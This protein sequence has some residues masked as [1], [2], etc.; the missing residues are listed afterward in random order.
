[1]SRLDSLFAPLGDLLTDHPEIE[2]VEI[3][4]LRVTARGLL[5]LDAVLNLGKEA[6]R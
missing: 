1:V 3:N 6:R 5:A 2:D 4:P